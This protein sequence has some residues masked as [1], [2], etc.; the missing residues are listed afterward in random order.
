MASIDQL[1]EYAMFM[2]TLI[3]YET[4]PRIQHIAQTIEHDDW[5]NLLH[6][7]W[8]CAEYMKHEY[9]RLCDRKKKKK[10]KESRMNE[11]QIGD[12]FTANQC[13]RCGEYYEADREHICRKKNSYPISL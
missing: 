9:C 2:D 10:K 7:V 1:M 4:T 13:P 12:V 5:Q 11:R 3:E 8:T 6:T